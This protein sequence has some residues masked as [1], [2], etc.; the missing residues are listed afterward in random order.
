MSILRVNARRKGRLDWSGWGLGGGGR[1]CGGGHDLPT[2]FAA[3]LPPTPTQSHPTTRSPSTAP[4]PLRLSHALARP[5]SH[6]PGRWP[7]QNP[8][9]VRRQLRRL[10]L[11]RMVLSVFIRNQCGM[12]RFCFCFFASFILIWKLFWDGIVA[13]PPSPLLVSH[14]CEVHPSLLSLPS[15]LS[16]LFQGHQGSR[17]TN[18]LYPLH[19]RDNFC[20]HYYNDHRDF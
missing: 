3:S 6:N 2:S 1:G 8:S 11:Y 20:H 5:S 16:T 10:A 7:T 14:T 19:P 12:G 9:L 15:T 17:H 13:R 18:C 4:V